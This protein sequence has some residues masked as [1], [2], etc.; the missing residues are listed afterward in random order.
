RPLEQFYPDDGWVEHDAEEIYE[1]SVAVLREALAK[2]G[3]AIEDVAAIGITNQRETVVIWDKATGKPIHRAIVWQDR[4]TAPTCERLLAA[5]REPQV[6]DI[7]GLLLDPYFS[8]TKIAWILDRVDGARARAEAGEL[9]AGTMDSWVIW[10]LTGGKVHATDATNASRT[11]LFDLKA[12]AWSDEMLDMLGVPRALLPTVLD[13]AGDYGSTA[14]ELLGRAIPI[15]GVAGDQQ[16]ALMGQGCIRAGEMKATY[17]TGCFMLVNTGEHLAPS[18]SRLLTTVAARLGGRATYAL[19]GSIFIAGAAL[20]WVNEGLGVPGGGAGVEKLAQTARADHGVVL[21]PA[22]TGLGAPW[23]DA[24]ARGGLFGMTRDTGLAEIAQ[25]AFD[26]CALQTRDLI[27][28]MRADA[29]GAFGRDVELRIDGGMSRSAW[30]SQRLADLTGVAVGRATYMET[31]A[32]G[33][34]LFAGLGAGVY[35]N[36]EEAIAARPSTERMDP[37]LSSHGREAA[38]ARWLDAVARVK[39]TA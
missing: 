24:N 2:S 33:A 16:A 38:Y 21:V 4:R 32:L 28:A 30:F 15:R 11:M 37:A 3:R 27:E 18:R 17:G 8:G 35:A 31:T 6:T 20:Q 23:W 1:A 14:P 26:A 5:G 25:A 10:K 39:T 19:E 12:Q 13:C 22:F 36:V 9:L 7:T 34:A 29:P